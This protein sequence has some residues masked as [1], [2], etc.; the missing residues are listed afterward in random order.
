MSKFVAEVGDGAVAALHA[1]LT[2]SV[3]G[4]AVRDADLG[5]VWGVDAFERVDGI[6]RGRRTGVSP[7]RGQ[8]R[9]RLASEGFYV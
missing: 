3:A 7:R 5:C 2:R 8:A 9:R 1:L 6:D 4:L